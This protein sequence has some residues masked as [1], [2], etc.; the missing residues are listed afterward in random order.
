MSGESQLGESQ[1]SGDPQG[2]LA[3]ALGAV[4]PSRTAIFVNGEPRELAGR[5]TLADALAVLGAPKVG[6]A[7][8]RNGAIVPRSLHASTRLDDGDRLEIVTF[9]GG[10]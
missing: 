10:G 9:V 2:S 4:R 3:A 8:E 1:I 5:P 7:V 6:I